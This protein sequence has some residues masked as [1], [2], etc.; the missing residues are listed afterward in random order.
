MANETVLIVEDEKL[1]RW[2]LQERLKR[3][4]FGV[5]EASTGAEAVAALAAETV[6]LILLDYRLPDMNGLDVLRRAMELQP[7]APVILMT[8]YSSVGSAVEA[9]KLGAHD[10][11]TK[12]FDHDEMIVIVRRALEASRLRREVRRL[13]EE[14][15]QR[16]GLSSIIGRSAPMLEV[17][18]LVEKIARSRA[19]TV[20]ITGESGTGK[21]LVAK[22]IHYSSDRAALPFLNIT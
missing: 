10:Y 12:P 16:Y 15:Q 3:E 2:S 19:A 7:D 4:G 22:A 17:F 5:L 9:I 8:A 20:L 13:R 1:A 21:D 18:A 6:D 14:Q 11:I